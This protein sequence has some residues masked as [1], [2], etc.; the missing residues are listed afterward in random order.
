M[1]RA[2]AVSP[3]SGRTPPS[4]PGVEWIARR[5]RRRGVAAS[6]RRRYGRRRSLRRH[7]SRRA[8]LR[9]RPDQCGGRGA[10]RPGRRRPARG[11]AIPADVV[12][13]G[14]RCRELSD[15][16]GSKRRGEMRG[17]GRAEE[18]ALDGAATARRVRSGRSRA[19]PALP[20]DR[21]RRRAVA[22]RAAADAS[23]SFTS[24]I[25]R[26]AVVRWLAADTGYG[27]TFELDDGHPG[28]YDWDTVL[29]AGRHACCARAAPCA[30]CPFPLPLLGVAAIGQSRGRAPPADTRRCS[31]P[32][33]CARSRIRTGCAIV[34]TSPLPRAGARPSGSKRGSRERTAGRTHGRHDQEISLW[35]IRRSSR[36][37]APSFRR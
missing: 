12:A 36:R 11:A 10:P 37:S 1:A 14:A 20:L 31:R 2:R 17:G 34:T 22:R 15:Y 27:R 16:A 29:D 3:R 26:A 18:P 4:L 13:G 28:G 35:T 7:G 32:A 8:A 33:R 23:R 21:A 9:F 25:S 5:S 6:A 19:A 30:A 24:T